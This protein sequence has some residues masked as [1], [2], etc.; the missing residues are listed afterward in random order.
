MQR[1][2][3]ADNLESL[4]G[5]PCSQLF[6]TQVVHAAGLVCRSPGL[7]SSSKRQI[8]PPLQKSQTLFG[9]CYSVDPISEAQAQALS[10]EI[11]GLL[12]RTIFSAFYRS[13]S[14][15]MLDDPNSVVKSDIYLV[16]ILPILP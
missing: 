2:L 9:P 13:G 6:S 3:A 4:L 8:V 11:I 15:G 5:M 14:G 7:A 1:S 12:H 16:N 10:C